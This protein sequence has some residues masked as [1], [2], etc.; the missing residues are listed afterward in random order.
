MDK[1]KA[2]INKRKANL[3]SSST[4]TSESS[5][6]KKGEIEKQRLEIVLEDQ[7]KQ[8]KVKEEKIKK[9]L[10]EIEQKL[11][12]KNEPKKKESTGAVVPNDPTNSPSH[13]SPC[14]QQKQRELQ[15]VN[16]SISKTEIIN[17]LRR[18][19]QPI[20]LFGEDDAARYARLC[21]YKQENLDEIRTLAGTNIFET[22]LKMNEEEFKK[23]GT[24][25]TESKDDATELLKKVNEIEMTEDKS[26]A[27]VKNYAKYEMLL[28]KKTAIIDKCQYVLDWC[29]TMIKL[30]EKELAPILEREEVQSAEGKQKL[31]I[32]RQ[33]RRYIKPLLDLLEKRDVSEEILNPLFLVANYT[34]LGEY[35]KANEKYMELAIG[36]APWPMGVTMVGIHERSGRTKIFS[37]QV[38]HILND[39]TQRKYIQSI[40]R[41]V[42]VCQRNFQKPGS[43]KEVKAAEENK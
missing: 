7:K 34:L 22:D 9:E 29:K 21:K 24:V 39:E 27:K 5:W 14:S 35:N 30:W 32:F 8:E 1:L 26:G 33:C 10:L 37:S 25:I 36:N 31:G 42:S 4:R 20:T 6:V 18:Y 12:K 11:K 43:A 15:L 3:N 13:S 2:E 41:L 16:L 40:M 28:K 17:R 19:Q 23:K 38:A